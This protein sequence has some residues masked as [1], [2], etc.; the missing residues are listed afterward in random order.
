MKFNGHP[1]NLAQLAEGLEPS[2]GTSPA[3]PPDGRRCAPLV[4]PTDASPERPAEAGGVQQDG[5][6]GKIW[7]SKTSLDH[8]D[9]Q[10]P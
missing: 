2:R 8:L 5:P 3:G 10:G 1:L 9:L 4:G 7:E 6:A